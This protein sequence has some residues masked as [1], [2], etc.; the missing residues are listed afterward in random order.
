MEGWIARL[1]KQAT[2]QK[3]F[4]HSSFRPGQ[5]ELIDNI[6][7][8]RDVLGIM[9]TGAGKS[10]CYQVP[11]LM[12][13]GITLVISPLISLMK[14]QVNALTQSGVQA[15]YIN[16]SL[17]AQEYS[18]VLRRALNG[19][20]KLLYVAPERLVTADFLRLTEQLKIAMVTIDEAHCIS[21]WGQDFR[22]AYLKIIEFIKQLSYRPVVSA[23]TATATPEVRDDI[24]DTLSLVNPYTITTGFDRKNLF[25]TVR[26]PQDKFGEVLEIMN[27][28]RAKSTIIYCTTR[29]TVEEVCQK[30]IDQG[31]AA[32]RYHAG[33]SDW[34]RQANQNDF[35]YDR[36]TIMVATN[37]FG[38]GIDKS[39]VGLIIHYNMPKSLEAYY[40]EA[41]R[42]GRDGEEAHCILLYSG[43]DVRLNQF[44]IENSESVN[45]DLSEAARQAVKE[46]DRERLKE[47]TFYCA[48]TD[49]LREYILKYFGDTTSNFCG[50]CSNCNTQF[51]TVDITIPAQK[52]ISCVYRVGE[53]NKAFGKTMIANI[54]RGSKNKKIMELGLNTLSTHGIMPEISINQIK[55]YID[56]LVANNYLQLTND[57]YSVLALTARSAEIIRD[58][59]TVT[60]Q[61]PLET[62]PRKAKAITPDLD[63]DHDL[64]ARLK[65]LRGRLA[66]EAQ[67]PAYIV[68]TDASLRDMCQKLP[69]TRD[70]FLAVSGVGE[71]K[72]E[73]YSKLFTAVIKEYLGE[74]V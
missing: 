60:M 53:Q 33:L 36:S 39:N 7:A 63:M 74:N 41:G 56:Y 67:V 6:L 25:F 4:G 29:K 38:M 49:C 44:L 10:L 55:Q 30:L 40:Q 19:E 5:A 52:I 15:A 71:V 11:A 70:E 24:I 12:L 32:T 13:P 48:T 18:T 23:F 59:K 66:F 57:R 17:T 37:A 8:G 21:Q 64:F 72:A 68:F 34:E 61:L 27:Q 62:K 54:L 2:L 3:Y 28:D 22:P 31:F 14:D 58:K 73:K 69:R 46:K 35:L 20:Y 16:S 50:K 45:N 65:N 1:D 51:Q 42:A 9:P 47:M 43:Q 26:K